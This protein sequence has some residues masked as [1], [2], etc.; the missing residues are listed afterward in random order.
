MFIYS[1]VFVISFLLCGIDY[2]NNR[3]LRGVLYTFFCVFLILL[4]GLKAVGVDNDSINY[5]DI[6]TSTENYTV[7]EIISGNYWE[8]IE[9]G[10]MLLNKVVYLL[11][12]NITQLFLIV[13][14]IT[15]LLNYRFFFKENRYVFTA[16]LFYL[17]FFYLYRD[18]TQIRYALSCSV[19]FWSVYFLLR[20]KYVLFALALLLAIL[21]H[22]T[23]VILLIL[24]PVCYFIKN[25]YVYAILPILC[26]VGLVYNP[27][28]LLLALGG[29]PEHMAIY[30]DEEGGGG[31]M[32]SAF[33]IFIIAIYLF[34]YQKK[35]KG[36]DF[37]F[38]FYFRLFALGVAL[39]LLFIQSAIFQRFTY[40]LFQFA[41]ILLPKMLYSLQNKTE[42]KWSI[43]IIHLMIICFLLYYGLKLIS[44]TIIRPYF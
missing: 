44:P 13:A 23:A 6:F 42:N 38:H 5:N 19:S 40:L 2:S 32:V 35:L 29:V 43:A 33:G 4:P 11:G 10:Y 39:N 16:L 3:T 31:F 28:P 8:N 21:F 37:E 34:F 14:I 36:M 18:F 27:F 20:K 26:L 7:S 17:S 25:R 41:V 15:G 22:S 12:G 1:L 24:L 9:R 30:L